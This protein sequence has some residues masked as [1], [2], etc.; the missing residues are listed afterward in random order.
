MRIPLTCCQ[1]LYILCFLAVV[2]FF[3]Q[4]FSS[5]GFA[6]VDSLIRELPKLSDSSRIHTLI[7][8]ATEY[9]AEG[10]HDKALKYGLMAVE[11][12]RTHNFAYLQFFSNA[13]LSIFYRQQNNYQ[14]SLEYAQKSVAICREKYP[15]GLHRAVLRVGDAF[16]GINLD[17]ALTYLL[18]ANQLSVIAN[19]SAKISACFQELGLVYLNKQ[20]YLKAIEYAQKS[21]TIEQALGSNDVRYG[22]N[23]IADAY[24]HLGQYANAEPLVRQALA[25]AQQSGDKNDIA[26]FSETLADALE[27]LGKYQEA[28]KYYKQTYTL[29]REIFNAEKA[30]EILL[31]QQR[32]DAAEAER[33]R[34][35]AE[36]AAREA[37]NRRNL[38]QYSL[39][40]LVV[41]GFLFAVVF[42]GKLE[43]SLRWLNL[44]LVVS[45]IMVFELVQVVLDPFIQEKTQNIRLYLFA[46]SAGIA[47]L[48]APFHAMLE[49]FLR[50][51]LSRSKSSAQG[52]GA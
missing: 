4:G 3:T 8:I 41:M 2:L 21:M 29:E 34:Q 22:L 18:E 46:F 38:T 44:L 23:N 19:D 43:V 37:E 27:G 35:A 1:R 6:Q 31:I 36:H 30:K 32:H 49:N 11:Q 13:Q 26:A 14:K 10:D 24:N 33:V 12:S 16:K 15:Q 50:R 28:L 20:D 45:L 7:D 9:A 25:L 47:L 40:F 48:L 39:L 5:Q 51:R 17:S 42:L 52:E